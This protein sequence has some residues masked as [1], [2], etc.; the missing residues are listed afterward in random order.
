ML[1]VN[2]FRESAGIK[3]SPHK[4]CVELIDLF[5]ETTDQQIK[6]RAKFEDFS[7]SA[8][9]ESMVFY[10]CA[11]LQLIR[12]REFDY[13]QNDSAVAVPCCLSCCVL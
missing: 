13:L 1:G 9:S 10:Q 7:D 4:I 6:I 11:E 3:L 5:R 2:A 8:L 12:I